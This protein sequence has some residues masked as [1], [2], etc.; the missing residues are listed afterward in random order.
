MKQNKVNNELL[1][2][3]RIQHKLSQSELGERLGRA[4]ATISRYETGKKNPSLPTLCAYAEYFGVTVDH[5]L[6]K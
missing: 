1:H 6:S 3:L 4:K 5:L 2:K